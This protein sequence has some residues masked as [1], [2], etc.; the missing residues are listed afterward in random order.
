M[1]K[2]DELKSLQ[3]SRS[4][5]YGSF[6]DVSKKVD[7]VMNSL[8]AHNLNINGHST[9]PEGFETALFYMVSKLVRLCATPLHEDSALDLSSYANLWLEIIRTENENL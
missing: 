9:F 7:E 8:R 3:K 2:E 6:L 4:S 5:Y 1:N